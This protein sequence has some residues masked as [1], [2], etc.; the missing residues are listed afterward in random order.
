MAAWK[1][2]LNLMQWASGVNMGKPLKFRVLSVARMKANHGG[3][4]GL[5]QA[6]GVVFM[7]STRVLN[8]PLGQ[9]TLA[10]EL[11]HI[12]AFRALRTIQ[13]Y[14][15]V[16]DY[17]FEA[18]GFGMSKVYREHLGLTPNPGFSRNMARTVAQ[19]SATEVRLIMTTGPAY[20]KKNGKREMDKYRQMEYFAAF[21]GDFLKLHL[22]VPDALSRMGRVF[23]RVGNG[24]TY[25]QAFKET[26]GFTV[27]HAVSEVTAFFQQTEGSPAARLKGTYLEQFSHKISR[28]KVSSKPGPGQP[29]S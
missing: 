14:H 23:E 7:A 12:Q 27:N 20:F 24:E 3:V 11:G 6:N 17:F 4:L 5:A 9:G 13:C 29:D 8:D 2:D 26:Y 19:L 18:H 10:H 28:Q 1:F 22:G 16:P 15:K 25:A 21:F